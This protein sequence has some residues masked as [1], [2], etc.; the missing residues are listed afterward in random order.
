MKKPETFVLQY[1]VLCFLDVGATSDFGYSVVL[2]CVAQAS[3]AM[4]NAIGQTLSLCFLTFLCFARMRVFI[5]TK[6]VNKNS[7][8][9]SR[10]LNSN[11]NFLKQIILYTNYDDIIMYQPKFQILLGER[12]N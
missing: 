12:Q 7:R 1:S 11:Y 2:E 4:R 5:L 6:W 9:E 10:F 3:Q 8:E